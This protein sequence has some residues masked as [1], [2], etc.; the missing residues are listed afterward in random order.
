MMKLRLIALVT[1]LSSDIVHA[2]PFVLDDTPIVLADFARDTYSIFSPL[3]F[4]K[5]PQAW[6]YVRAAHE[7]QQRGLDEIILCDA[8][9][10]V[11]E[12]SAAA[13]FCN[14]ERSKV[15]APLPSATF[16]VAAAA[17][18]VNRDAIPG[19]PQ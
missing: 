8:A 2:Q 7:R 15:V 16:T 3:S 1:L 12:A 18:P 19:T 10:H 13:I 11:A 4:C 14:T 9:G 5:G 17:E 6:L